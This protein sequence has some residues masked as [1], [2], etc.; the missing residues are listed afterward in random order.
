MAKGITR[1]KKLLNFIFQSI[2]DINDLFNSVHHGSS[3]GSI[4]QLSSIRKS[5]RN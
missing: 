2:E 5:N 1:E 4:L 3:L